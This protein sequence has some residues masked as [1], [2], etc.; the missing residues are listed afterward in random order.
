MVEPRTSYDLSDLLACGRGDLLGPGRPQL[1]LPPMLMFDRV[2]SIS[3]TGGA[4]GKGL[5]AASLAVAGNRDLDWI[6]SCRVWGAPVLPGSL[7]LDALWQLTGFYLGWLGA[8]G[9]GRA[10]GVGEVKFSGTITPNDKRVDYVVNLKRVVLRRI[11]LAVADGIVKCDERV[12]YVA[13]D[14]VVG[15]AEMGNPKMHEPPAVA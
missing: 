7:G 2:D 10:L 15:L 8:P 12:I 9:K 6:F 1:P 11:K 4:Y 3:K 14:L 13:N 5:V